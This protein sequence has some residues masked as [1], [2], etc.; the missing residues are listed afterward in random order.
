MNG[1]PTRSIVSGLVWGAVIPTLLWAALFVGLL[2]V[3]PYYRRTFQDFG[4]QLPAA[5]LFVI[6]VADWVA[7]YW[8]VLPLFLP[9]VLVP[10]VII[11]VLLSR[12]PSRIPSRLW[13]G[14]MMLLPLL[15]AALV[16]IALSLAQT[17]LQESLSK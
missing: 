6:K 1:H 15:A 3:V 4:M 8:Y 11:I 10:D 13:S 14:L 16:L 12:L 2:I 17:K 5:A 9:F 7:A